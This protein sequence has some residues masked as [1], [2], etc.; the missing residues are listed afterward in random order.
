VPA[1]VDVRLPRDAVL[2][3]TARHPF[4]DGTTGTWTDAADL[5]PGKSTLTGPDGQI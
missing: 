5:I 4:W 1:G 2:E 3:T